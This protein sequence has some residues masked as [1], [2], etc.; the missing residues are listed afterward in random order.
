VLHDANLIT[1]LTGGLVAALI[2][3]L[4]AH[5]VGVSPIVGYLAAGI[6]VGPFTPGFVANGAIASELAELGVVLLM[7]GVGLHFRARELL[8]VRAVALPGAVVQ[9]A[10]ATGLGAVVA[11]LLGW[12]VG[13][14]IVFGVAVSV[15]ST[16]VLTRVLGDNG[17]L[18]A[19]AGH[20]A[21]GWL[22][23]EDLFTVVVLVLM[24]AL[25]PGARGDA[26]A[27]AGT[28][29]LALLKLVALVALT[30]LIG[31]RVM[32]WLLTRVART[33]S[34]ELFTLS[35]LSVALG[36]AAGS[37]VLFGAS[38]ALGAFL[39]GMVVGQSEFGT[40]AA[41]DALPMRDAFAVLF[42][43]SVGMLFDPSALFE[44][45]A[46][47]LAT[48]AVV[49]VAKP[50]AAYL[51]VRWLG[52]PRRTALIVGLALAQIGEF[53]FIVAVL[54][55]QLEL[56]PD[57]AMQVLVVVSIVSIALNP[58]AYRFLPRLLARFPSEA[59]PLEGTAALPRAEQ[60]A[61]VVGYG[62]IGRMLT[63]LLAENGVAPTVIEMN[64]ESVRELRASG[65]RA[66]Y[67]DATSIEVLEQAG[68]ATARGLIFAASGTPPDAV[69]RAARTLKR[70]IRVIARAGQLREAAEARS[71]GANVVVT[72]EAEVALAM[73]EALLTGLGATGEQLDRARDTVRD[74]IRADIDAEPARATAT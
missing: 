32:P 35:V 58:L 25:A 12:G 44:N 37:A 28:L 11:V 69:I 48:L 67:G 21:V 30:I 36:I 38:M 8:A 66:L 23:V 10:V 6:L 14:G 51:V 55:T 7:F 49:L 34:R 70:D 53:S 47:I 71:A 15:A 26:L 43:V 22:I 46:P 65:V 27:V 5:R 74:A 60:H 73:A 41:S 1:T 3:G 16:V 56:L 39:A 42:F 59:M 20:V 17:L 4:G 57:R 19:P 63:R 31:R 13:A 2:M 45:V 64:L 29:G 33:R 40:R 52:R 24:P 61:I 50:L 54:G 68:A 62:P 18:H 9:I 72:A